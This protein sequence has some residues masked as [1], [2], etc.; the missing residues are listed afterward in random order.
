MSQTAEWQCLSVQDFFTQQ[1]W[2]GKKSPQILSSS[3]ITEV[4]TP[5]TSDFTSEKRGF[6]TIGY[7]FCPH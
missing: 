3:V 2:N 7:V 5:I 4:N 6:S 1:N